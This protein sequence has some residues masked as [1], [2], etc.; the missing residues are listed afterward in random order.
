MLNSS[1]T[2][3]TLDALKEDQTSIRDE[4]YRRF[5]TLHQGINV[6]L[7]NTSTLDEKLHSLSLF[8]HLSARSNETQ[9]R[10]SVD[11]RLRRAEK[12]IPQSRRLPKVGTLAHRGKRFQKLPILKSTEVTGDPIG[13][14]PAENNRKTTECSR[15]NPFRLVKPAILIQEENGI[16]SKELIALED[17]RF[18]SASS[19]R[20]LALI[21]YIQKLRLILWLLER[22]N[23]LTFRYNYLG[24][25][26]R[27]HL[28]YQGA[29]NS[30]W[31]L[32]NTYTDLLRSLRAR[33]IDL[34]TTVPWIRKKAWLQYMFDR[35]R[36]Q[37]NNAETT[38]QIIVNTWEHFPIP[39]EGEV[40]QYY[41]TLP[42]SSIN[43]GSVCALDWRNGETMKPLNEDVNFGEYDYL[44]GYSALL[45]PWQD[46]GY[47]T[48]LDSSLD[49]RGAVWP[50]DPP[51]DDTFSSALVL[52]QSPEMFTN[53]GH[54]NVVK[55]KHGEL[56]STASW[57]LQESLLQKR[58]IIAWER[59][60]AA[61]VSSKLPEEKQRSTWTD[62]Y[63]TQFYYHYPGGSNLERNVTDQ[64]QYQVKGSRKTS[65]NQTQYK[66]SS[67]RVAISQMTAD[68][69]GVCGRCKRYKRHLD[70][71][72]GL[73]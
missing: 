45:V 42:K 13:L 20:K 41:L 68:F 63:S 31:D 6:L 56:A 65:T 36:D 28:G 14:P 52:D 5:D 54:P 55:R 10:Q 71:K 69:G 60:S 50:F 49:G 21:Q 12:Q 33:N 3:D 29:L 48:D 16:M 17:K 24:R 53:L 8:D 40:P 34:S 22:R 32:A 7:K 27:S 70:R 18:N 43:E 23:Y 11:A 61:C 2:I 9:W 72:I 1:L 19:N 15:A 58:V 38:M 51:S 30:S 44:Q 37:D 47:A 59:T 66:C 25:P 46:Q 62:D 67:C 39:D 4:S 57:T 73:S 64:Y 26:A 35:V